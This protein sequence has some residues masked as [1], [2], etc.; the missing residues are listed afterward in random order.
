MI[1]AMS[2]RDIDSVDRYNRYAEDWRFHH[3]LIWEIPSVAMAILAGILTVSFSFLGPLPRVAL[4]GLGA[5]LIFG[6]FLAVLKH[7]FGADLRTNFLE[8]LGQDKTIRSPEGLDYLN[9]KRI[10]EGRGELPRLYGWLIKR[11]SE[12][13]L[14]CFM[15]V[16]VTVLIFLV[17]WADLAIIL[18][19]EISAKR[20]YRA[21]SI[22]E[23]THNQT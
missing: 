6:L 1:K 14:I 16:I 7:R 23:Q 10:E 2:K 9:R 3:K 8:D 22:L 11:S 21:L 18:G 12:I 5:G 13:Y 17:V 15:F 4:L 20:K 19:M